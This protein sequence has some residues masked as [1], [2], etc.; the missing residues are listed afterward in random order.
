MPA[1]NYLLLVDGRVIGGSYWCSA[2]DIKDGQRWAS[3]GPAGYSLGHLD[4]ETAERV[5][6]R[7]YAINPDLTDRQIA[8]DER[9][10]QARLAQEEA[11][12][13]EYAEA[14]R[15]KRECDD[16]PDPA[17]WVLP[18]HHFLI[19]DPA[20]VATVKAWL[21]AHDLDDVSGI[22]E[23]RV[24]QRAACARA[25]RHRRSCRAS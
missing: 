17:V 5:Q 20:D 25:G 7:K 9:E 10:Q 24:E 12:E 15:R 11:E 22:H 13:Q 16:E 6:I 18:T 21:D 2:A 4:R 19:A 8:D 1:A 3:W 14:Q 23:I